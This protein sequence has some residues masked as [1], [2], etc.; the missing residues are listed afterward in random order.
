M[1]EQNLNKIDQPERELIWKLKDEGLT[2][3]ALAKR[4]NV[5]IATI[6][7]VVQDRRQRTNV[8]SATAEKT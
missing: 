7:R 8:R 5:S 3:T 4:F 2:L 6:S 1:W